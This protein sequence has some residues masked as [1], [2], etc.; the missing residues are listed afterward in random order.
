METLIEYLIPLIVLAI[1]LFSR[2]RSASKKKPARSDAKREKK[3]GYFERLNQRLKEAYEKEKRAQQVEDDYQ[4][5]D[6]W[7]RDEDEEDYPETGG[8]SAYHESEADPEPGKGIRMKSDRAEETEDAIRQDRSAQPY[9]PGT[10]PEPSDSGY[11]PARM[12]RAELR[13]AVVWSE[14]L[15]PPKAL[16]EE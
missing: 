11:V 2:I 9:T 10:V 13:K 6:P 1:I 12:S 4:E 16:R 3:P 5:A 15:S 14:I 8:D 7:A